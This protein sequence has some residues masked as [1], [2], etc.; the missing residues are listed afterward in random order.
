M[1]RRERSQ[2]RTRADGPRDFP[3][4]QTIA[5]GFAGGGE[6]RSARKLYAREMKEALVY[7]VWRPS[8]VRKCVR[9]II[10]FSDEDYE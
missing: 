5:E 2:S 3:K 10:S 9:P 6:S 1:D 7:A 4:I 8:K